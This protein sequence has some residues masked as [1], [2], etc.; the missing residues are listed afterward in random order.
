VIL[1]AL[2]LGAGGC[3]HKHHINDQVPNEVTKVTQ[4]PYTLA[5]PDI[6]L[7]NAGNLVP[8]P[9]YKI[10]ALDILSIKVSFAGK[11]DVDTEIIANYF[12]V[13]PDGKVDFGFNHGT[14]TLA[15]QELEQAKKSVEAFM[16]LKYKGPLNVAVDLAQSNQALQQIRGEHLIRPD[17]TVGLGTYGSV[18]VDG[19][20]VEL[21]KAVIEKHLSQFLLNPK[22][23]VDIAGFNSQVYYVISDQAGA[24]QKIFRLP[25][26]GKETV[27]D[28]IANVYGLTP[29]S[30]KHFIWV[31]RPAH[32]PDETEFT[33]R[34]DWKG[35]T[36][37]GRG[38]TNYQLTAGDRVYVMAA[39]LITADTYLGRVLAPIERLLGIT[40][41]GAT[42]YASVGGIIPGATGINGVGVP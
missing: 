25:I 12:G 20:T 34:V 8:L 5:P 26:T 24:G 21:A 28:A 18:L 4:P 15:G 22:I 16:L 39:P 13:S 10:A 1:L 30:S 40:L 11:K 37:R 19:M 41:L 33:M 42:T 32:K 6:L 35:I 29:V 14:L 9:P 27:L 36:E 17:G 2:A 7:I 31:A 23:S 3:M 38:Q